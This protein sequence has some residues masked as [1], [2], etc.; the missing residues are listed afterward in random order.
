MTKHSYFEQAT[1]WAAEQQDSDRRSRKTAWLV[2][3]VAVGTAAFEAV[4][5]AMLMPLKTVQPITLLVDRQTG[6]VETVDPNSPRRI[7]ADDALTQSL[8]AQYRSEEHTSELQSPDH[9]VCRLL[10][11]K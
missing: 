10:L 6:F 7:S 11:E 8:L 5:L 3:G 1:S 4:A 9:L 2:A